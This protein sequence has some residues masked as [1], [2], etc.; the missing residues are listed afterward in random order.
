MLWLFDS[1]TQF[2]K[3]PEWAVPVWD[4]IDD[5]CIV[6]DSEDENKL[7]YIDIFNAFR[8]MVESLLG[9]H[10]TNMGCGPEDFAALCQ[11]FGSTDAGK[12]VLEQILAVDDFVS[13]KSMMS[14]RNR[15]LELES[16]RALQNLSEKLEDEAAHGEE[17]PPPE[18]TEED[19]F[20]AQLQQA[21]EMSMREAAQAGIAT[22]VHPDDI[23]RQEEE[24]CEH[25]A[26]V[27][28]HHRNSCFSPR[29]SSPAACFLRMQC[30][31]SSTPASLCISLAL[32][33][34]SHLALR[35]V[36]S[37]AFH[38]QTEDADLKMALALS[39]QLEEE[40]Q[41]REEE[42]IPPPEVLPPAP[43]AEPPTYNP[44]APVA[45]PAAPPPA[46]MPPVRPPTGGGSTL[47]PLPSLPGMPRAPPPQVRTEAQIQAA[48]AASRAQAMAAEARE[49]EMREKEAE[50]ENQLRQQ[51]QQQGQASAA[52]MRARAEHLKRQRDLILA[53][54][55]KAREAEAVNSRP[56][57]AQPEPQRAPEPVQPSSALHRGAGFSS[58]EPVADAHRAR[59]SVALASSMKASLL[60]EDAATLDLHHRVEAHQKKVDLELTKAQLRAEVEAERGARGF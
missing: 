5:N 55:K 26:R 47:G 10:L 53:Q 19:D 24:V 35:H 58:G 59:L 11:Q 50:K 1:V 46:K 37:P 31:S 2:L 60:G 29:A 25:A 54:R 30:H 48:E 8:E 51:E 57:A 44:P 17:P 22:G 23:A 56:A 9:M 4:F 15:E 18:P 14:K 45:E 39:L 28:G 21:L 52:E 41:R 3:G 42:N 20:E 34:T 32:S 16:L 49:R 13:F 38:P 43:V 27:H 33:H 40:Q 12:E 7:A 6:F 36:L